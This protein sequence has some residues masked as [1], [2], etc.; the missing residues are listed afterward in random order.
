MK[1][2]VRVKPNSRT[3]SVEK[4]DDDSYRVSV[5]APPEKG[6]ANIAT[7]SALADYFH[8]PKSQIA[9]LAGHTAHTKIVE[10]ID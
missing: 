6:K 7:V 3:T 1:F 5:L 2:T 8:V 4:L 9:I 10:V